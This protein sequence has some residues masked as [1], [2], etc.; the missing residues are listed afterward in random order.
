MVPWV[1]RVLGVLRRVLLRVLRASSSYSPAEVLTRMPPDK[2]LE[3]RAVL[4]GRLG[5]DEDVLLIYAQQMGEPLL[6][7]RYC[8]ERFPEQPDIY[9]KLLRLLL[10]RPAQ[11]QAAAQRRQRAR[12]RLCRGLESS[13][14]GFGTGP[15]ELDRH[16][17][18]ELA[19][20]AEDVTIYVPALQLLERHY[21]CFDP[22][23]VLEVLD[24]DLPL[25]KV[26]GAFA[27]PL[28]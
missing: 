28:L 7:Q 13:R 22:L 25:Q 6:A 14:S 19:R 18:D 1:R 5:Q 15:G 27:A 9:L 23:E 12:Q 8:A 4:L 3:E 11:A 17:L 26:C 21:A 24:P 16:A 20:E 2:L 10:P